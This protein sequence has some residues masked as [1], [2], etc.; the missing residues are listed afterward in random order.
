[1]NECHIDV[2]LCCHKIQRISRVGCHRVSTRYFSFSF[3]PLGLLCRVPG[4]NHPPRSESSSGYYSPQLH[5]YKVYGLIA[6]LIAR[7]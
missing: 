1:M 5:R 6:G 2:H 3:D 4:V 7:G